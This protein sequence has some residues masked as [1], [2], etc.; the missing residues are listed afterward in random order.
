VREVAKAPPPHSVKI[1]GNRSS[2]CRFDDGPASRTAHPTNMDDAE[3]T[4]STVPMIRNVT[5][6]ACVAS[7]YW[8][9]N[10]GFFPIFF[11]SDRL[12]L[13]DTLEN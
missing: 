8:L 9:I 10:M 5:H 3:T 11:T 12:S 6:H 13:G 4:K 1:A 2:A 7:R